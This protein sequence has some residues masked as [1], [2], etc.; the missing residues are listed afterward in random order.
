MTDDRTRF[1]LPAAISIAILAVSTASIFIRFAQSE[2]TP[3]IVIAA[4]RLTFASLLLTPIVLTRHADD[5]RKFTGTQLLFGALSGVFLA[6]HFA[7]WITSLEYTSVAS[8]AVFVSTGPLWVALLSPMLLNE[9]LTRFAMS[10]MGLALAGGVII[11]LSDGCGW[12][13]GLT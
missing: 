5:V 3:S 8:S 11:G 10:G 13:G 4:L 9:R 12:N 2:A 7:T 1:V 6:I